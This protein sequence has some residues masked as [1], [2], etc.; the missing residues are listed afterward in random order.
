VA[1]ADSIADEFWEE[2]RLISHFVLDPI[3]ML[4]DIG[5][6]LNYPNLYE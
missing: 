2:Q 1:V 4:F 5:E 6:H 3:G